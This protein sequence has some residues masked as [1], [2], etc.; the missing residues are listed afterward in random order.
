[1]RNTRHSFHFLSSLTTTLTEPVVFSDDIEY[2]NI[3][4]ADNFQYYLTTY[5]PTTS[6]WTA[7]YHKD[8][9]PRIILAEFQLKK[10]PSWSD[11]TLNQLTPE[12]CLHLKRTQI[13]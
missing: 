10:V 9:N 8:S 2:S 13:K 4:T 1:M 5:S 6:D 12:Y 3:E 7:T 11:D